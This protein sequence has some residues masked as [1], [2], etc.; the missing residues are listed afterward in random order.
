MSK[1]Q[2]CHVSLAKYDGVVEFSLGLVII[3]VLVGADF[4]LNLLS[5]PKLCL[6]NNFNVVFNNDKC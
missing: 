2:N 6:Q 5:V 4:K 3:D 1:H